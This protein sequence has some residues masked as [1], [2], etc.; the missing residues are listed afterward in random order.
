MLA[1][2]RDGEL[3]N[4]AIGR[5]KTPY[6]YIFRHNL[7]VFHRLHVIKTKSA[8]CPSS[9]TIFHGWHSIRSKE[10]YRFRGAACSYFNI[11][12]YNKYCIF[13]KDMLPRAVPESCI[14]LL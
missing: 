4:T 10:K 14:K 6:T 1:I 3:R 13:F 5:P 11:Q 9:Y 12:R 8:Y 7:K 2:R